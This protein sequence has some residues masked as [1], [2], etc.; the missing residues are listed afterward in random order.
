MNP[1]LTL[2]D[3][4]SSEQVLIAITVAPGDLPRAARPIMLTLGVADKP[5]VIY[6]GTY[7]EL[8]TLLDLA[9]RDFQP[10]TPPQDTAAPAITQPGLFDL[11]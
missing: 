8:P 3:P 2:T 1:M 6:T 9:W 7:A 10:T 5:P 4:L 11:F